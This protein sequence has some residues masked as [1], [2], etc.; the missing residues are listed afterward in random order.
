MAP[1]GYTGKYVFFGPSSTQKISTLTDVLGQTAPYLRIVQTDRYLELTAV[2]DGLRKVL[3]LIDRD[4]LGARARP[5]KPTVGELIA[6]ALLELDRLSSDRQ[7]RTRALPTFANDFLNRRLARRLMDRY[8]VQD[9]AAEFDRR[10][11]TALKAISQATGDDGL[12]PVLERLRA[13]LAELESTFPPA[14]PR[15]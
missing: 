7:V 13:T 6:L 8:S 3:P 15:Q 11:A 1:A 4:R 5:D 14:G 12:D 9:L 10:F 2:Q